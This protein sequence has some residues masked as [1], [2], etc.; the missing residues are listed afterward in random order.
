[1]K[2]QIDIELIQ[3]IVHKDATALEQLYDQYE[4]PMYAFAYRMLKDSMMAEEAVQEL[5]MRIWNSADKFD[6]YQGKLSTWMF[7]LIRNIS[8]D[9][10]RKKKS[11]MPEPMAPVEQLDILADTS[12]NI[13][14]EVEMK[15]L[16]DQVKEAL[17]DLNPDQK[18]VVEWIYYEGLT[19]QE[20]ADTHSIPLGTV[21]S[22]VRLALKQLSAKLTDLG[23]REI[24]T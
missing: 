14:A 18:Q 7:T 23:R 1:M 19:Q 8:I 20:V 9:L 21:K 6:S 2:N 17:N 4:R 24:Q 3:R 12:H 16:S 11:R 13:E 15:W 22:R 5:F 10:I